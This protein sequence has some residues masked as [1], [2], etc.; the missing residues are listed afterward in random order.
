[1]HRYITS[2]DG[3]HLWSWPVFS[4]LLKRWKSFQLFPPNSVSARYKQ[5]HP[6]PVFPN[7]IS[8][9]R[10]WIKNVELKINHNT[11]LSSSCYCPRASWGR[12]GGREMQVC[13]RP[14]Q[15]ICTFAQHGKDMLY[16][17]RERPRCPQDLPRAAHP[18]RSRHSLIFFPTSCFPAFFTKQRCH[19]STL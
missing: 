18:H 3:Q 4:Q 1:M 12:G 6:H 16:A 2:N 17:S 10:I 19:A 7:A 15:P 14:K 11:K 5:H 8:M 13:F 9:L